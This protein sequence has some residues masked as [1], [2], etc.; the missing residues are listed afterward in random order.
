MDEAR[1]NERRKARR[2]LR[3]KRNERKLLELQRKLHMQQTGEDISR[4]RSSTTISDGAVSQNGIIISRRHSM[5][6]PVTPVG[7]DINKRSISVHSERSSDLDSPGRFIARKTE[8]VAIRG[9]LSRLA[10]PKQAIAIGRPLPSAISFGKDL[11]NLPKMEKKNMTIKQSI[12]VPNLPSLDSKTNDVVIDFNIHED[13]NESD[14][15][16]RDEEEG[17]FV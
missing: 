13:D 6:A 8:G 17:L 9:I 11:D 1:K 12:S 14:H 5:D 10:R 15:P 7:L 16:K 4:R 3:I 2:E